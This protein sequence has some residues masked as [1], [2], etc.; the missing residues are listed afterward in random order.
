[1]IVQKVRMHEKSFVLSDAFVCMDRVLVN[2]CYHDVLRDYLVTTQY[3][4]SLLEEAQKVQLM[5]Q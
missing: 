1:M 2:N 3:F 5:I 4:V